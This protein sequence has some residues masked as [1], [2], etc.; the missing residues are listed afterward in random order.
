MITIVSTLFESVW[1]GLNQSC[2]FTPFFL[3]NCSSS[4][5]LNGIEHEQPFQVQQQILYGLRSRLWLGHTRTF[6]SLSLNHPHVA[7]VLKCF[8]TVWIVHDLW[9]LVKWVCHLLS[10]LG[11]CTHELFQCW[12]HPFCIC[13]WVFSLFFI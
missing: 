12:Q 6:T 1:M 9:E 11:I 7:A 8:L 13:T 3:Q 2:T 10:P 4:V 5:R